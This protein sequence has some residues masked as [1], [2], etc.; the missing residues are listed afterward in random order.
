M[1]EDDAWENRWCGRV[2]DRCR[3]SLE[4]RHRFQRRR[5]QRGCR[6]DVAPASVGG[7]HATKSRTVARNSRMT[8][9][10]VSS[11]MTATR[12]SA[13]GHL[14]LSRVSAPWRG[15]KSAPTARR[16]T[17]ER[18]L[19]SFGRKIDLSRRCRATRVAETRVDGE[20]FVAHRARASTKRRDCVAHNV[21][22]AE[23]WGSLFHVRSST[24]LD[25][26]AM[27]AA[28]ILQRQPRWYDGNGMAGCRLQP[29]LG[30]AHRS[31]LHPKRTVLHCQGS[32]PPR[33]TYTDY[34]SGRR[35][36]SDITL[37]ATVFRN[38]EPILDSLNVHQ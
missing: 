37:R 33:R 32:I 8:V 11:V 28:H 21:S 18:E 24:R 12:R 7:D 26:A 20:L 17:S 5:L 34:R 38:A 6:N 16:Q 4:Q 2:Q 31:T 15:T 9:S 30:S 35:L 25:I 1:G 23:G 13:P 3:V 14:R 10:L 19:D 29:C 27:E 36:R 22:S